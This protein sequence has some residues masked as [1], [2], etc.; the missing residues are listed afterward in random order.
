LVLIIGGMLLICGLGCCGGGGW[1]I[2]SMLK[3]TEFGEQTQEYADA[4]KAFK[5]QLITQGPSP[6]HQGTGLK[7]P[8]GVTEVEYTSGDLTLGAW[9]NKPA[10]GEKKPAVLFLH[11]GYEFDNLDWEQCQPFRDAGFVTMTPMLRG[12]NGQL[13]SFTW[14]YDEV[15]DVLA[16]ADELI[17]LRGVDPSRVYV[18]GHEAGGTLAMLAAMTSKKFRACASLSGSPDQVVSVRM[19]PLDLPFD[20]EDRKE[21]TMRSPLAF[22]RSF[23]CPARL[24]YGKDEFPINLHNIALAKKAAEAG[25]DVV[26]VEVA[27]KELAAAAAAIPRAIQ[28]F[29][30]K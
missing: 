4:R 1:L 29:N 13:G 26:A 30:Q 7:L 19:F 6:Q 22:P 15:D 28:F 17:K 18:A 25:R 16:A 20:V 21:L 10:R 14:H 12:E 8:P 5:T 9:V 11:G 2:W 24:Y 27:G 23:Q 3:P